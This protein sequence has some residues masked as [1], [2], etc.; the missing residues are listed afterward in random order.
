MDRGDS[1]LSLGTF[2]KVLF[3]G[4]RIGWIAADRCRIEKL[5]AIRGASDDGG[6][7]LM[8]AAVNELCLS[9]TEAGAHEQGLFPTHARGAGGALPLR[10][11]A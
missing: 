6:S 2:S 8:Q 10:L 3:P 4:L 11:T 9:G 1:V 7:L 5:C